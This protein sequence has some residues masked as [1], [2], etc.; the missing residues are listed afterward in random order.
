MVHIHDVPRITTR[1]FA[2][3]G[4]IHAPEAVDGFEGGPLPDL[5]CEP[6]HAILDLL[7]LQLAIKAT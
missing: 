2:I 7:G 4:L 3:A 5:G 1:G 6:K